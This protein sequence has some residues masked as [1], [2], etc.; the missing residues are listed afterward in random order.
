MSQELSNG[1]SGPY[2]PAPLNQVSQSLVEYVNTLVLER[3][4]ELN[5]TS[6]GWEYWSMGGIKSAELDYFTRELGLSTGSFDS[7]SDDWHPLIE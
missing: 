1:T 5:R 2:I 4:I 7:R 3:G 6:A